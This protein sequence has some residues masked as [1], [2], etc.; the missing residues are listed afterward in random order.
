MAADRA[1][2]TI[3]FRRLAGFDTADGA[4]NDAAARPVRRPRRLRR[5]GAALRARGCAPK[6]SVDAERA[7]RMNRVNPKFVLRNHLAEVAIRDARRRATSAK[8]SGC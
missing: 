6:R 2:F 4:A 5:L 3:T 8:C 7:A 1:D